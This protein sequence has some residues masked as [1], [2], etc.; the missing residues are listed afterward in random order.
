MAEEEFVDDPSPF[1]LEAITTPGPYLEV[2][3]PSHFALTALPDGELLGEFSRDWLQLDEE[4]STYA[5]QTP[6]GGRPIFL[7]VIA[8]L[9][10]NEYVI[11][12]GAG[13]HTTYKLSKTRVFNHSSG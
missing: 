7:R 2:S 1:N 10:N 9:K 5:C 8:V 4:T 11:A 6:D 13:I 3:W 12:D